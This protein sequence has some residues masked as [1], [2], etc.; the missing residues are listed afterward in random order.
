[1]YYQKAVLFAVA[2]LLASSG[3]ALADNAPK[4]SLSLDPTVITADAGGDASDR[5]PLMMALDKIGAAKPLDDL[6]LNIYGWVESG[7]SYNH[8]HHGHED[9]IVPGPFNHEVGNHY[10]LNQF[11]LRFE[12]QVDSK[13]FDVGGMVEFLYGADAAF[14]HSGGMA[15]DGVDPTTSLSDSQIYNI[16]YQAE[17]QFDF[18]QAYVD[19]NIPVGNG[20]TFRLGK[21][22]TLLGNE[23]VDPTQNLFYSHSWAFNCVPF[24]QTGVLGM[25]KFNDQ[26]K[27]IAGITRGWDMTLEDNNGAIDGLGNIAYTPDDE[28]SVVFN[29]NI[30][31]QNNGD[32]SHYRTVLDPIIGWQ[33]TKE[34]KLTTECLFIFDGGYNTEDAAPGVTHAYGDIWSLSIYGS[35]VLNDYLTVNGRVEKIHS[36]WDPFYPL[37]STSDTSQINVAGDF[38]STI[39][40]YSFTLGVTVTPLPKNAILKNLSIRPE[41]RYDMSEDPVFT[42][43]GSTFK[44]QITFAADVIFKF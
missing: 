30:G 39:N 36:Y 13:T 20:L 19:V 7:Y 40:I 6:K 16:K 35:Y 9:E 37:G 21:F 42:Q 27:V 41:I 5:A 17:P 33:V 38:A 10:M 3:L 18:T 11:D 26:W 22:V 15:L 8:R 23:T 43:H 1:M 29:W 24:S 44:D 4:T 28:L 14:S 31:P 32:N 25:Y 12:R 2:G 34:F